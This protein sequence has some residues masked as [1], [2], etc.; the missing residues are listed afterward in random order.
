MQFR[1]HERAIRHQRASVR[2]RR[3]VTLSVRGRVCA[4]VYW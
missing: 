4:F 2:S 3:R 1:R